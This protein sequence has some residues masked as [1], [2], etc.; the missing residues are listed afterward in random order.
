M[1]RKGFSALLA[2]FI[3][4]SAAAGI[5]AEELLTDGSVPETAAAEEWQFEDA[6]EILFSGSDQ[7]AEEPAGEVFDE[8]IPETNT[9]WSE[10]EQPVEAPDAEETA[11]SGEDMEDPDDEDAA[12]SEEVIEDA[13]AEDLPESGE[14]MLP[15]TELGSMTDASVIKPGSTYT[16]SM[17]D[18][19]KA[20]YYK[21]TLSSSGR[22]SLTATAKMRRINFKI[23]NSDGKQLWAKDPSMNS[24]TQVI[25][26]DETIDLTK[27]TYFFVVSRYSSYNGEYR[28]SFKFASA[29]ESFTETGTGTD[30]VM[31]SADGISTGRQYAGQIAL[32]DD[33]DFYRF[34]LG[35]SGRITFKAQAWFEYQHYYIYDSEGKSLWD[36]T[37]HWNTTTYETSVEQILDLTSGTYYLA[38][39]KYSGRT[40]N[41]KFS[42]NFVSAGESFAETGT[43]TDN[44]MA[45]ANSISFGKQYAGQIALNDDR[46]YY[47]FS[48]K[49]S[50]RITVKASAQIEYVHYYVY[51]ASSKTLWERTPKWDTTT[52]ESKIEQSLDLTAGTYYLAA[53]RDSGKTGNYSFRV[54]FAST[55]ESFAETGTG[56]DNDMSSAGKIS[57]GKQYNGQIALNDT[58][59]YYRFSL[60]TSGRITF[61]ANAQLEYVRYFIYD[62]ASKSLWEKTFK[63]N[64]TTYESNAEQSLD[65]TSGTY[66]LAVKKDSG[67]TGNYSF[68]V[69]FSSAGESFAESGNGVDNSIPAANSISLEQNYNGQIAVN[70]DADYYKLTIPKD[71][72]ITFSARA[73]VEQI[74]YYIYNSDGGTLWSKYL[75]WDS[76]THLSAI[77]A[78][79]TMKKG[80]YY[81]GVKKNGGRTGNYSFKFE[82]K[83]IPQAKSAIIGFYNSVKGA[84]IRW[85]KVE[86][87]TGYALYR[88]RA[89]DGT[90]RVATINNPNTLQCYDNG[91]QYNCWGRVY[92][93]YVKP[94]YGE[95]EGPKSNEVTLQRLAPMKFTSWKNSSPGNVSLE[96]QC[97]VNENKALGYEVQYATSTSDLYNQRGTFTKVS[98]NGR[99]TLKKT[100]YGLL[101]NRTYYFRIRCYVNYT[102][103][104]TGLTTRTWSQYSDVVSVKV[105]K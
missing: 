73:A 61:K 9:D 14:D 32:N 66:Y 48:L 86:G 79:I 16:G 6:D 72:T 77:D 41:Y 30:N 78:E 88:K 23:Y 34:S 42:I 12:Q 63:W 83:S 98:V 3:A 37:P 53:K 76:A 20:D 33:C 100:I 11:E 51:D 25:S 85:T 68:R 55:G 104:Q 101:R 94:L 69:D 28:F 15:E 84:D 90:K 50:G 93:Y 95:A 58:I 26:A 70:D 46:D 81:L 10:E 43:G 82:K 17:T 87:C 40:G 71:G 96:W 91:I 99:N 57:L 7:D 60:G 29:G 2:L 75:G 64:T 62:T 18:D 56:T 4:F 47:R 103:S 36:R 44:A 27:G 24:T 102:H 80:V 38:V 59:D 52:Y 13:E 1:R 97:T 31:A 45:S 67:K 54:D 49:T 74:Y 35:S 39:K 105:L 92:V 19:N 21:F 8:V 5:P 22:F 65:L 89:A